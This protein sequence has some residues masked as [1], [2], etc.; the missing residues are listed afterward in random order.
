MRTGAM[1]ANVATSSS[2]SVPS[3]STD[4]RLRTIASSSSSAPPGSTVV[5]AD[6]A[7]TGRTHRPSTASSSAGV[8]GFE[9]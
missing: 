4:I 7:L 6:A 1:R 2:I 8:T 3:S 5:A 9:T